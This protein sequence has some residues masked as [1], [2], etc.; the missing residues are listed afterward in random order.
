MAAP[1]RRVNVR[2][3]A[4]GFSSRPPIVLS[5][6][7]PF[8][9]AVLAH[10]RGA[11]DL[12]R[13]DSPSGPSRSRLVGSAVRERA[14]HQQP[15]RRL[16]IASNRLMY[17]WTI[18]RRHSMRQARRNSLRHSLS[19]QLSVERR[20]TRSS[21]ETREEI[22]ERGSNPSEVW[23]GRTARVRDA[24]AHLVDRLAALVAR[25][26][27]RLEPLSL[28]C[29]SDHALSAG[30]AHSR[31][32]ACMLL[33]D[34]T[35]AGRCG[36]AL[37]TPARRHMTLAVRS[38]GPRP[39]LRCT[40]PD[41]CSLACCRAFCA[42]ICSQMTIPGAILGFSSSCAR[43]CASRG[44]AGSMRGASTRPTC[45]LP[46]WEVEAGRLPGAAVLPLAA[47]AAHLA[48]PNS[49]PTLSAWLHV[50]GVGTGSLRGDQER[51]VATWLLRMSATLRDVRPRRRLD[52]RPRAG[53]RAGH[54][55][56]QHRPHAGRRL[57]AAPGRQGAR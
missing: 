17:R 26:S 14:R 28:S 21:T 19:L 44:R 45:F 41:G 30:A 16:Q 35:L 12:S 51:S 24:T 4:L 23:H 29:A 56:R 54:L 33:L 50:L 1:V 10:R 11:T 5:S 38:A 13:D 8:L 36:L 47:S 52:S 39:A 34:Y 48:A 43:R 15:A 27:L 6:P 55:G 53:P 49:S 2:P 42:T 32:R 3:A 9:L 31:T 57:R 37:A 25:P 20:P 40:P 46:F 18:L 22:F 7:G